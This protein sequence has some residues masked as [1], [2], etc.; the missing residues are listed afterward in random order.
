MNQVRKV[1]RAYAQQREVIDLNRF[2]HKLRV[3]RKPIRRRRR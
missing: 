2:W 3:F 1:S